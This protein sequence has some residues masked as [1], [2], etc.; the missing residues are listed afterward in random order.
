MINRSIL[1]IVNEVLTWKK[2]SDRYEKGFRTEFPLC[3]IN[4]LAEALTARYIEHTEPTT[5]C[6]GTG[7]CKMGSYTTS[8]GKT[9]TE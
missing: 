4:E 6:E 5:E 2:D 8:A 3:T 9:W 1:E 7:N